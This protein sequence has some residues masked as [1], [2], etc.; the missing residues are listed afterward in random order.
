MTDVNETPNLPASYSFQI[1]EGAAAGAVVGS[2]IQ[3]TDPDAGANGQLRYY[4]LN[5]GNA[6]SVSADNR[7]AI[8]AITGVITANVAL[9]YE[10]GT[11]S[12]S[13]TV[14]ARD[15][16]GGTGALEDSATV[17]IAITNVNEANDFAQSNYS[18]SINENVA[19]GSAVGTVHATD[20]DSDQNAFGQQRYSFVHEGT[21]NGVSWD[22]RYQIDAL[23]GAIT[24]VGVPDYEAGSPARTYQVMAR[25]N[26]GQAGGNEDLANVTIAVQNLNEAPSFAQSYSWSV[27]ENSASGTSIGLVL[28][29]D[30]DAAGSAWS[31]LRY[32]FR[33]GNPTSG[34]YNFSQVSSDGRYTIDA[35][36]GTITSVGAL[37]YE[38]GTPTGSYTI[39]ARD[40][41]A[42]PGY[43]MA[44]TTVTIAIID[45]NDAPDIVS[46]TAFDVDENVAAGT[47][48][49]TVSAVDQ[50]PAGT[51][52]GQLRY[53]FLNGGTASGTSLDGLYAIDAVTG[54]I[55]ANRVP[56]HE[57]DGPSGSYTVAVRDHGGTGDYLQDTVSITIA[58]NDLNEANAIPASYGFNINENVAVGT[59]VGFVAATDL[60]S[61]GV[62]FGQQRYYFLNGAAAES[63]SQDGRYAIDAVTGVI[64]TASSPN[65]EAG[66][67][68]V[69]YTVVARDN[70]GVGTYN[71]VSTT[72]TIG[73]NNL[74]EAGEFTAAEYPFTIAEN[75]AVGTLVGAVSV[76]DPD[77]P[78]DP[79]AEQR[80]YFTWGNLQNQVVSQTS[81]DGRY[82]IDQLTGEI[83]VNGPID[84]EAGPASATYKVL[85]RDNR[86]EPGFNARTSFVTIGVTDVNEAPVIAGDFD[87]TVREDA[88]VGSVVTQVIASDPDSALLPSGR[89][90]YYF[91][92]GGI[93]GALSGDGRYAID[94]LTGIVTVANPLNHEAAGPNASYNVI[95]RDNEG[96]EG[97][98]ESSV[99]FTIAISDVNEAP[100]ITG[101]FDAAVNENAAL[102]TLVT[103][104]AAADPD[105]ASVANGRLR[106][107]FL[108]GTQTAAVSA[109]GRYAIDAVTG[110]V[111]VA[112]PLDLRPAM[113]VELSS[114]RPR[115]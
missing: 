4:F 22:G 102:G 69:A 110:A 91:D 27:G 74:N 86:G 109:D 90:R 94:G 39:A 80:Y 28:A 58:V 101:N 30:P 70:L 25:D 21:T 99:T 108:D 44:A 57:V 63:T 1:A 84:F 104:I 82:I 73:V 5:G 16:S 52:N 10:A 72:V 15:N 31:E 24:A 2:A 62:A 37:D 67:P 98:L 14:V 36:T 81:Q 12:Q 105:F 41:Q 66:N 65:Y 49:T 8:N 32:A 38:A 97:G 87:A 115:Q 79:F 29:T 111:T 51:P 33:T 71:Q 6:V 45:L 43:L 88:A 113:S 78:G 50:D 89:I 13:Y 59:T 11:P 96:A 114:G 56:D 112:G 53:Y 26:A 83:R 107:H 18:F 19:A 54:A 92:N 60:D 64:T 103:Q 34:G 35:V 61:P 68:S 23:T 40:N 77:A 85:A 20:P 42:Q 93:L 17:T 75:T 7:Y 46:G 3:A 9:D 48:V 100:T 55:T 47:L 106:Y 95:V 76:V